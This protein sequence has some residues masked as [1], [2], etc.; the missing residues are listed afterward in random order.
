VE[1]GGAVGD[2]RTFVPGAPRYEDGK[3][4]LVFLHTNNAGEWMTFGFGLGKFE[5]VSDLRG[6]ELLAR[7]EPQEK[8]FGLDEA[9]GSLHVEK[10]RGGPEFLLFVES[11][12]ASDAPARETY[13]VNSSDV[14]LATFPE[15]RPHAE[16][17]IPIAQS[18]RPSYLPDRRLPPLLRRSDR[19]DRARWT[20]CVLSSDVRVEQCFRRRHQ[21]HADWTRG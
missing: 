17:F 14:V 4:Y 1:L 18:T 21:L 8:I 13:F 2:R 16:R 20:E 7:G 9:D 12:I 19:R 10:L 3:R 15:F 6:R 11:R 5:F